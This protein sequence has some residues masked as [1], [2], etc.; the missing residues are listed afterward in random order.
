MLEIRNLKKKVGDFTLSVDL[1]LGETERLGIQG[2][3]GIGKT[4]LFRVVS[5]LIPLAADGSEG[6]VFVHGRD[7]THLP[8]EKREIGFVFQDSALFSAYSALENLVLPLK[9][10][11]VSVSDAKAQ[12]MAALERTGLSQLASRSTDQLSAGERQRVAVLRAIL[13]RPKVLLF[14]EIFA[15][16]DEKTRNEFRTFLKAEIDQS[17]TPVLMIS[18]DASDFS[19]LMTSLAEMRSQ[20]GNREIRELLRKP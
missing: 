9:W 15:N 4:T 19:G 1:K 10:R 17:A 2:M 20:G 6:R 7:V 8:A 11:G 3:S 13:T 16:I 12:A 5:G 14:D 18:H